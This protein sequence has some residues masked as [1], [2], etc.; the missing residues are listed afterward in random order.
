MALSHREQIGQ[1]QISEAVDNLDMAY[2]RVRRA[3]DDAS[4]P[5]VV[6]VTDNSGFYVV[7]PDCGAHTRISRHLINGEHP[8]QWWQ[9]RCC[10]TV[11]RVPRAER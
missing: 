2:Q 4:L 6:H 5:V 7:C 8:S 11:V 9:T 1:Q 3:L 10:A